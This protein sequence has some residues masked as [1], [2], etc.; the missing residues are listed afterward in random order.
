[1]RD[2]RSGAL[3]RRRALFIN[4]GKIYVIGLFSAFSFTMATDSRDELN[5][6][7]EELTQLDQQ[8]DNL[9]ARRSKLL[10]RKKRLEKML[11]PDPATKPKIWDKTDFPWSAGVE[12]IRNTLFGIQSFRPQQLEVI[13]AVLSGMDC[14]VIMPTGGGKSLCFQLPAF[15]TEGFTLVVSPLVSLM[16]DQLMAL[17]QLNIHEASLLCASTT[18]EQLR[19]V[20]DS[21]ISSNHSLRLLY[22]T[23]EKLAKSKRFMNRLEKAYTS[24]RLDRIVIDEV[25]CC[26]QWGHDFRPDYKFLGVMKRQFPGVPILGLTATATQD[27]VEDVTKMLSIPNA[28][29]FRAPLNRPNLIY[30][31]HSK[32]ANAEAA[33]DKICSIISTRFP[34]QS[35]II[36]CLSQKETE[37]VASQLRKR[38]IS[39]HCYHANM[40]PETR[41]QVHREWAKNERQVVVATVAFGMGIDKPDVRFVMHHSMSKSLENYYQESGRAGR[42]IAGPAYCLLFVTFAD[43]FRHSTMVFTEQTGLDKLY[44]M[45][46]YAF[47]LMHCRRQ[48]IAQH[49]SEQWTSVECNQMCDHCQE[50]Y[51]PSL[52][53][54]DVSTYVHQLLSILSNAK[55]RNQRLTPLK[56]L[57]AWSG[58][59]ST[60][61]RVD[62]ADAAT[63]MEKT[64]A[65]RIIVQ[66]LIRQY[67]REDFHFTPYSTISYITA[68]D[69][70][71]LLD[72]PEHHV[73]MNLHAT[74][75]AN[76]SDSN[77]DTQKQHSAAK[78]TVNRKR[79]SA[80]NDNVRKK[81][82]VMLTCDN[83]VYSQC[84]SPVVIDDD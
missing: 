73:M 28:I 56:L 7:M 47:D 52:V 22:V 76:A 35:G 8:I 31:V 69:R 84:P 60:M 51:K 50:S 19:T 72:L 80:M 33:M 49:F 65:E 23:P 62:G 24:K 14:L 46:G 27:V 9:I 36:Y 11:N 74:S 26:S 41:S 81:N 39:A 61:L 18:P 32:P 16:E 78:T 29:I 70:S 5:S 83:E 67:L 42:D 64:E 59:G 38:E 4:K 77:C 37:E 44:A 13:N 20:Q 21:M 82:K 3:C 79:V 75:A 30:E 6:V 63:K 45:A 2:R 1:M 58:R 66:L 40:D 17:Q 54:T 15:V 53:K 71:D 34:G 48:L 55:S 12:H 43:V 68:G 57:E 10:K 25:H